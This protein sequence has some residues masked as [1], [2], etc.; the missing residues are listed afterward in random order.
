VAGTGGSSGGLRIEISPEL[1]RGGVEGLWATVRPELTAAPRRDA[2]DLATRYAAS[3]GYQ[4]VHA[5]RGSELAAVAVVRQPGEGGD[6]RLRGIRV[7]TV[8]DLLY[9]PS[10]R[11]AGLAA[12]RG[13][14]RAARAAG[15]DILLCSASARSVAPVLRKRGYLRLPANLHVLGRFP[16]MVPAP[17]SI[18]DWWFTRGDSGGDG[19]F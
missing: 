18:G 7:S 17:A 10:H 14:E 5:W 15:A 9:R 4:F 16:D 2:A 12:L 8:S 6:A 19:G 13:A 11:E 1:D 3:S